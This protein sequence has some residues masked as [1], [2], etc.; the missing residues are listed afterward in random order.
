L[1]LIQWTQEHQLMLYL[2]CLDFSH[3]MKY[4]GINWFNNLQL[5]ARRMKHGV[6]T[7]LSMEADDAIGLYQED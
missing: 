7:K 6:R 2:A 5:Q 3:L 1:M 4:N